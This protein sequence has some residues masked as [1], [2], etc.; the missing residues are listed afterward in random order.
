MA[1]LIYSEISD[2]F[3]DDLQA[4][5]AT[6]APFTAAEIAR[7]LN[8]AY[9]L[10][11]EA[12]GGAPIRATAGTLWNEAP[13]AD[14]K[15]ILTGKL[16]SVEEITHLYV[17]ADVGSVGDSAADAELERAELSEIIWRRRN[18]AGLGT[19][20]TPKLY[21]L[22]RTHTVTPADVNK[23][24][25]EFWP[26]K[27]GVYLPAEYVPQFT[28]IDSATVTTPAVNDLE[29]RDIAH[30][31]ALMKAPLVGRAE[32]APGIAALLSER[33]QARLER[34]LSALMEGKQDR[35]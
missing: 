24:R 15:G 28:A 13:T 17:S 26:A 22:V 33:T 1:V 9:A 27:S 35:P 4:N 25:C 23:L 16:T 30:L 32:L 7:A 34:K 10:I 6:D 19:Y 2:L 11:W 14:T 20:G 3:L 12:S 5:V 29:S 21:A 31:A 18:T 8:D